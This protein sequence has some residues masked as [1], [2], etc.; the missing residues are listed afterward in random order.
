MLAPHES[1]GR[2]TRAAAARIVRGP[3]ATAIAS[4]RS[5]PAISSTGARVFVEA[6]AVHRRHRDRRSARTGGR[7]ARVRGEVAGRRPANRMRCRGADP[8]DQQSLTWCFAADYLPDEDHTDRQARPSTSASGRSARRAGPARS[9]AGRSAT[10]SP[11]SRASARCSSATDR[12]R[13]AVRPVAR[14][15]HRRG[16]GISSPARYRSDITLA[17]GRRWTTG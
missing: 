1:G 10:S 14:A 9:S 7:R 13:I 15:A 3:Y 12:R 11:T 17:T 5:T 8:L 16:G 4:R 2:V 6:R